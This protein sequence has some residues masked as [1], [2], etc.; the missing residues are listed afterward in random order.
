MIRDWKTLHTD[1]PQ[2]QEAVDK[3]RII[4]F[5]DEIDI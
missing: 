2:L 1:I 5:P 3:I 4:E